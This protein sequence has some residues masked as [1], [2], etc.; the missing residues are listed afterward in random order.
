MST[1]V[2]LPPVQ[3]E[4]RQ[5]GTDA[6]TAN[7]EVPR[8]AVRIALDAKVSIRRAAEQYRVAD[9][10]DLSS[11]GCSVELMA[12]VNLDETVWIKLPGMEARQGLVSW[13]KDYTC[14]IE[15]DAPLHPSVMDMLA[16]R[17]GG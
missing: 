16:K 8:R 17:L 13:V 15:F 5:H 2:I 7:S 4:C 12:R 9:L 3:I 10:R 6:L 11:H 14:G 1:D